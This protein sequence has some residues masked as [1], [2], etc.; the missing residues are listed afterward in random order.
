MA[1]NDPVM[2]SSESTTIFGLTLVVG[3]GNNP[4]NLQMRQKAV[5]QVQLLVVAAVQGG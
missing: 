4:D 5:S 1:Q 2:E 3:S